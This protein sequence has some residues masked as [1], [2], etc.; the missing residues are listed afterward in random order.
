MKS[1][2]NISHLINLLA[3]VIVTFHVLPPAGHLSP[4]LLIDRSFN[5]TSSL[6]FLAF[7]EM[8]Q[9]PLDALSEVWIQMFLS[10]NNSVTLRPFTVYDQLPEA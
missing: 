3:L 8:S 1:G 5:S 9:Q 10:R 7:H 2:V 6:T 4:H